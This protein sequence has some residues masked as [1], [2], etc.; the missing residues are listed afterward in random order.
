MSVASAHRTATAAVPAQAPVAALLADMARDFHREWQRRFARPGVRPCASL[1]GD[2]L[3]LRMEEAFTPWER[4]VAQHAGGPA[5]VRKQLHELLD[6]LY[7]WLADQVERRLDCYVA[8]SR[9]LMNFADESISYAVTLRDMPR[10]FVM[11][12]PARSCSDA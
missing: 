12:P 10:S 1:D 9:V 4:E 5:T 8:E 6:D 2:T 3:L 7:P 11:Q